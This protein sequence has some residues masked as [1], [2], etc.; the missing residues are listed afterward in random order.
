VGSAL[1]SGGSPLRGDRV[2]PLRGVSPA[3]M[4]LQIH[5]ELVFECPEPDAPAARDAIV[6]AMECAMTLTVPLKVDA[7]LGRN[8]FEGK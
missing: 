1:A 5:D 2:T 7:H 3:L 6:A 4:L 8:W